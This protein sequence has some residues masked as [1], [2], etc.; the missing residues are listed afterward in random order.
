MSSG[1][2]IWAR[3][4][5]THSTMVRSP[6]RLVSSEPASLPAARMIALGAPEGMV[7]VGTSRIRGWLDMMGLFLQFHRRGRS[8]GDE[9]R[10]Q[11]GRY[12]GDQHPHEEVAV[13][14]RHLPT[15]PAAGVH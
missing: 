15:D 6:R 3:F 2:T 11:Q 13:A 9:A 5:S 10:Q 4:A 7:L 12:R 1:G 14:D 8:D